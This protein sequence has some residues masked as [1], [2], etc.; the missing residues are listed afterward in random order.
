MTRGR[1]SREAGTATGPRCH[2][3]ALVELALLGALLLLLLLIPL[4]A[5][6]WA[7]RRLAVLAA[8]R[9]AVWEAT[10]APPARPATAPA[11]ARVAL[12]RGRGGLVRAVATVEDDQ[13]NARSRQPEWGRLAD[14]P[15]LSA[16]LELHAVP[17]ETGTEAAGRVAVE[18][19]WL[20]G[21]PA[22]PIRALL[23]RLL[24]EDPIRVDFDA[25][26]EEATR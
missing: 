8:A 24:G 12:V 10:V 25:R 9:H 26:P 4:V 21:P 18:R 13:H 17:L 5:D 7:E 23:R 1:R 15:A 6:R 2:G 19:Q 22:W 16:A 20:G 3:Q 11:R 14:P